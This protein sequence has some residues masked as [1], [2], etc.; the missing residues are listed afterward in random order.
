MLYRENGKNC[1]FKYGVILEGKKTALDTQSGV[2]P[3]VK[4]LGVKVLY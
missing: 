3:L 2:L 1:V 4:H